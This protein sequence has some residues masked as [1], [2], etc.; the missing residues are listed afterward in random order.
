MKELRDSIRLLKSIGEHDLASDLLCAIAAMEELIDPHTDL[1]YTAIMRD[2]RQNQKDKVVPFEKA[3]KEAFDAAIDEEL[4]NPEQL[5]I[6]EAM[7]KAGI[8]AP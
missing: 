2:L 6:M 3:F 1:T 5:A 4:E 8:D 7:A